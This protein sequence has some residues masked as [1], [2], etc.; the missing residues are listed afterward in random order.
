MDGLAADHTL[1]PT[2]PDQADAGDPLASE[3]LRVVFLAPIDPPQTNKS[4]TDRIDH[5]K[6]Q[7]S[8][9]RRGVDAEF[10]VPNR[11]PINPFHGWNF[12]IRSLDLARSAHIL[13][14]HR[15]ADVIVS[16]F[17]SGGLGL[18]LSR[19]LA[20]FRTPVLLWDASISNPWRLVQLIQ[21]LVFS[22]YDGF[23][24]L[25]TSQ[26][27]LLSER[28][29]PNAVIRQIGYQVDEDFFHPRHNHD[30]AYVLSVGDDNSRDFVT[31]WQALWETEIPAV[32]KTRWRPETAELPHNDLIRCVADRLDDCGYRELYA[33]AAF[34]V[35]PLHL[36]R[37]PG[38]ITALFEAMAM[39]KAVIVSQSPIADD[40]VNNGVTGLVVPRNDV[41]TL[42]QQVFELWDDV[43]SRDRIGAA[44]RNHLESRWSTQALADAMLDCLHKMTNS[45][46]KQRRQEYELT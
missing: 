40:F 6:L 19:R 28:A 16:I 32:I 21:S 46:Q 41:A 13:L 1:R 3:R 36:T 29:K 4:S 8:L 2:A 26:C 33:A 18:L 14:F 12:F 5:E 24:M 44:A 39:G 25:T 45:R 9:R 30:A 23:M 27:D 35:I 37:H 43:A 31:L 38:G 7:R 22:R 17:E 42:R 34:V 15:R 10:V 11:W 20:F